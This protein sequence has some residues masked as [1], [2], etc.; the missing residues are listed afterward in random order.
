VHL[1][2][3]SNSE[4][5]VPRGNTRI[6]IDSRRSSELLNTQ[7]EGMCKDC[8]KPTLRQNVERSC[9]KAQSMQGMCRGEL[10]QVQNLRRV[11]SFQEG[12]RKFL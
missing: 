1:N 3:K 11:L 7:E 6:N 2:F 10:A 5:D 8:T 12:P 4:E 9:L